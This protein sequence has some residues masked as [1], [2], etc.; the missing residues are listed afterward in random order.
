MAPPVAVDIVIRRI[1]AILA[2]CM[3]G[4]GLFLG[5]PQ[6]SSAIAEPPASNGSED[7]AT[8]LQSAR[9]LSALF[10]YDRSGSLRS[11]DPNGIRYD[12][13]RVALQSL[14]HINRADGA[15]IAIEAAVSAFDDSYYRANTIV[16]WTRLNDG[17]SDDISKTI[18]DIVDRAKNKT[19]PNGGT[20]FT[21]AMSG[22]WDD[23]KDRGARGTCRVV[24]WFTDGADGVNTV[25]TE[26]CRPDSGL[27]DEMRRA[28]IVVVGLQLGPATDDLRAIATGNAATVQCGRNPVPSDWARGIYIQ[29]DDSAALRRLFGS[30]G[31]IVRGCTAQGDRKGHV[32]PGIRA[33]NITIS[34]PSQVNAVRLDAPDGTVITAAPRGSTTQGGYTAVAESDASYVSVTVDFPPGKGAGDWAVSAGQAIAPGDIDFCVFSGLHLVRVDPAT[35]PAA[36]ATDEMAYHAVDSAGAEANL[37]D[38]RDVAVGAAAV[39]ANG[40]IRKATATRAGNRVVVR[41]DS[42]STDARL[43]VRLT[44]QLTTISG[45]ALTPL[46]VDEGVGLMLNKAF[47]TV[48][49]IDQLDLGKAIRDQ[50]ATGRL[51]L[52]GSAM[53]PSKICFDQPAKLVVPQNQSGA[54]LDV[55]SGCIDL[56][57]GES[58]TID[59][60]VKPLTPTVGNG[61]AELPIKLLPVAGSEMDGQVASV[62]LPVVWRYENPREIGVLLA[63]VVLASLISIALPL[64]ALG[65]ANYITA[66]FEVGGL[67][68]EVIPVRIGADGPRRTQPLKGARDA[69][70]ALDQ[71]VVI[72]VSGRRKFTIGRVEFT[73]KAHLNP[74]RAPT[75][76]VRST[77]TKHRVLSSAPPPTGDGLTAAAPPGL[78]FFVVAVVSETDLND[79]TLPDVPAELVFLVRDQHISSPQLDPLMNSKIDWA[80][81]TARWREGVE[82]GVSPD[83]DS[84]VGD[85]DNFSHL[86][87]RVGD[88]ADGVGSFDHLNTDD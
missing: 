10:L 5:G 36:G 71:T 42:Q 13:L 68:G 14:A 32:D 78:G 39:A 56:A 31:N 35:V 20:N 38:Y 83:V 61:E 43:Q 72:P 7:I 12:G 70:L 23:L 15:P 63:V 74:L 57:K 59:V 29:A 28:G 82:I 45:L 30:L 21:Q 46:V 34:T 87:D 48:S 66:K 75:F 27:L 55:V 53:G 49:P 8:C 2:V 11:S 81:V 26:P 76:T 73:S 58:R 16:D 33:M 25:G 22:A 88:G 54:R 65:L 52:L 19:V 3:F 44:T 60:S 24:F 79:P 62:N 18:V 69:V 41:I 84:S 4:I 86:G 1:A 47:P 51:T 17:T 67:R 77:D 9:S 6:P 40:D 64:L 85:R 37:A 80:V 50:Q